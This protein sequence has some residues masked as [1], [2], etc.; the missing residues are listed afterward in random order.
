MVIIYVLAIAFTIGTLF[1]VVTAYPKN[2]R[3]Y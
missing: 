3:Y 1:N 2:R